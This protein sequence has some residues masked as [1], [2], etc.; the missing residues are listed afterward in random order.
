MNLFELH[1]G[2][3]YHEDTQWCLAWAWGADEARQIAQ[4]T[5]EYPL[6]SLV[7]WRCRIV[8]RRQLRDTTPRYAVPH[9]ERR[10]TVMRLAGWKEEIDAMC[11]SCG[12]YS[13]GLVYVCDECCQCAECGCDCSGCD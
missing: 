2:A 1:D 7:E 4:Q 11:N 9:E 3:P 8:P 12:L 5:A 10:Y 13:M 6:A